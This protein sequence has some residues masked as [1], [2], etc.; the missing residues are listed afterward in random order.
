MRGGAR[1]KM[2]FE[3][4][5][6]LLH[7]YV[8]QGFT[9]AKPIAVKYGVKPSSMSKFARLAGY[10]GKQG[11][12]P[13][14]WVQ[15]APTESIV[16]RVCRERLIKPADFFGPGRDKRLTDARREAIQLLRD[17]GFNMKAISRLMRRNYSTIRFWVHPHI[18]ASHNDRSR[19]Y[20]QELRAA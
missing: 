11:R 4:K 20:W 14:V 10:K 9:A 12:E 5:R 17:A 19:K 2:T 13:G 15:S 8:T 7:V 6:Y 3:Q 1:K 18:R 16:L